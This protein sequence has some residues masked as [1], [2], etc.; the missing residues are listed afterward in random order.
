MIDGAAGMA[1]IVHG[2]QRMKTRKTAKGS[3]T[4]RFVSVSTLSPSPGVTALAKPRGKKHPMMSLVYTIE[5]E[6]VAEGGFLVTV[7]ALPGC[8]TQAE[9]YEEA[10]S[11]AEDVIKLW[12]ETLARNGKP[13][14]KEP[15]P[16]GPSV[17]RVRVE[18]AL[19]A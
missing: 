5:L 16:D 4:G 18:A 3:A 8:C 12:V 2:E 7:P 10:I 19:T 11:M 15:V 13:V 6:P 9:S 1:R 17:A 14:P